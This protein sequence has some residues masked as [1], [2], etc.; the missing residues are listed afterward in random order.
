[1]NLKRLAFYGGIILVS[2]GCAADRVA[3]VTAP[4]G[5]AMRVSMTAARRPPLF[6]VDGRVLA[7]PSAAA[8]IDPQR[9]ANVEI[10]KGAAA[11]DR[12]GPDA[13]NGVVLVTLKH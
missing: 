3:G 10:L 13:A 12:Y 4:A 7:G 1:M 11:I 9:I 2:G 5:D 8:P 6:V